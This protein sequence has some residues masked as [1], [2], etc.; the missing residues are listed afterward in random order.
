MTD[1]FAHD[2]MTPAELVRIAGEIIASHVSNNPVPVNDLPQ[3]IANVH[4][5]LTVAAGMIGRVEETKPVP[6]MSPRAAIKP[7]YLICLECGAKQKTLKRHLET[8]HGL[9][10]ADY[11]AKYEL[12]NDYPTVAP[13]Y[14]RERSE[15]AKRSGLGERMRQGKSAAA[16]ARKGGT[17]RAAT[18]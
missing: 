18:G 4:G 16:K 8:A 6:I 1:D 12:G 9:T 13:N 7:N 17:L 10:P 3:L 2:E 14:S 15:W 11:R 5:A